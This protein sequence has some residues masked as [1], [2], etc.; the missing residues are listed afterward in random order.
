MTGKIATYLVFIVLGLALPGSAFAHPGRADS[1]GGHVCRTNCAKWGLSQG[2]YHTHGGSKDKGKSKGKSKS[3]SCKGRKKAKIGGKTKCLSAGQF[4]S[5]KHKKQYL[6]YGFSCSKKD[7]NGR[8]HLVKTKRAK[9][10]RIPSW[11]KAA[12]VNCNAL[13]HRYDLVTLQGSRSRETLLRQRYTSLWYDEDADEW[14][15]ISR[16]PWRKITNLG[17]TVKSTTSITLQDVQ[18]GDKY[19]ERVEFIWRV[20]SGD[21]RLTYT[22]TKLTKDGIFP[23]RGSAICVM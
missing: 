7:K 1:N 18:S 9:R 20:K 12:I 16:T 15:R 21:G 19:R 13:E 2:Q 11:T 17:K 8:Y 14:I 4:C 6:K 5:R 10:F 23:L 22:R 3:K